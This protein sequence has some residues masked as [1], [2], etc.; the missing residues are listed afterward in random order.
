MASKETSLN[1][2]DRCLVYGAQAVGCIAG[3][4]SIA[5]GVYNCVTFSANC[6]VAG[7][8]LGVFGFLLVVFEA[9]YCCLMFECTDKVYDFSQRFPPFL[10]A[11]I[12][13]IAAIIPLILCVSSISMW[14]ACGLLAACGILYG[15]RALRK[16]IDSSG[17]SGD[18]AAAANR[19]TEMSDSRTSLVNKN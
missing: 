16:K 10:K 5:M 3:V 13:I 4:L 18:G 1:A 8:I 17:D 15:V 11:V 2:G 6:F 19:D 12:Y 14:F 9:P 7:I